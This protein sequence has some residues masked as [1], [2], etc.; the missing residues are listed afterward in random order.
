[1]KEKGDITMELRIV[2]PITSRHKMNSFVNV[3]EDTPK[4]GIRAK[5][6]KQ[7]LTVTMG[8][9]FVSDGGHFYR[10]KTGETIARHLRDYTMHDTSE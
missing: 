3:K 1:M 9:A 8:K 4:F 10:K 7:S 2:L 6:K 5:Y